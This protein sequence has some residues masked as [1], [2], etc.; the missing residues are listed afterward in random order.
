LWGTEKK[1]RGGFGGDSVA[2]VVQKHANHL[3]AVVKISMVNWKG[4]TGGEG[5]GSAGKTEQLAG[6]KVGIMHMTMFPQF[7][8]VC[9]K[10]LI[11]DEDVW[12]LYDVPRDMN[13]EI[14]DRVVDR[15]GDVETVEWWTMLWSREDLSPIELR[16]RW[17]CSSQTAAAILYH[18][19][20]E[21]K[22][23]ERRGKMAKKRK[24]E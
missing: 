19:L 5:C 23:N 7:Q 21:I 14:E 17:Q 4:G 16:G 8:R 18:R 15:G 22:K 1:T 3:T 20:E 12:L 9:L 13:R 11:T 24:T 2:K 10:N 6:D